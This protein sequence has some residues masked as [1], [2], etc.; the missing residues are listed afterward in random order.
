MN[1]YQ[2]EQREWAKHMKICIR[3]KASDERTKSGKTE[4]AE[5]AK[6]RARYYDRDKVKK[7]RM[8]A[9]EIQIC[10]DCFCSDERTLTGMTYCRAC[11]ARYRRYYHVRLDAC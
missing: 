3:C 9:K 1:E 5:C 8:I 10:P 4:C 11:A 2:K 7:I 6:K